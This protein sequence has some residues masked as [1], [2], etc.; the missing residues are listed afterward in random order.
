MPVKCSQSILLSLY[1]SLVGSL[2]SE[3]ALPHV[4]NLPMS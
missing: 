4:Q 3:K 2:S 1:D